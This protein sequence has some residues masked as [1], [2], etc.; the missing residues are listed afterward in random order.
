M[1]DSLEEVLTKAAN[2]L[3]SYQE[4]ITQLGED[5]PVDVHPE[6]SFGELFAIL[7]N[8]KVKLINELNK[9]QVTKI[10]EETLH[11]ID[12]AI[13]LVIDDPSTEDKVN[14]MQYLVFGA[15]APLT[16]VLK[17]VQHLVRVIRHM[18]ED[19]KKVERTRG[20]SEIKHYKQYII[21]F[22]LFLFT[23]GNIQANQEAPMKISSSAFVHGKPIPSKYTCSGSDVSP[24]LAISDVPEG[25]QSLALI[26]D[27]P[28]APMGTFVH[29][30]AWNIPSNTKEL[31]EGGKVPN[32][33]KNDF[34]NNRYGGPCP[35]PGKPHRYFFKLYA[36]DTKI[37]LPEGASKKQL[38]SAIEG[39]ILEKAELVGTFQR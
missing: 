5:S 28:D 20:S 15:H 38:E 17:D 33:G 18:D 34:K 13:D 23:A 39:H 21:L 16:K 6:E 14:A 7:I 35:P 36:L 30:V 4:E 25:T 12:K 37:S 2:A 19:K 11:A 29:W 24:P 26:M 8:A 1:M 31:S 22:I 9:K 3:T 27:D 10:S 32:Q